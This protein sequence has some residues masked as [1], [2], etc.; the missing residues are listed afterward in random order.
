M[1]DGWNV[2]SG[3]ADKSGPPQRVH[4][5]EKESENDEGFF[6]KKRKKIWKKKSRKMGIRAHKFRTFGEFCPFPTRHA[7][8]HTMEGKGGKRG[9]PQMHYKPSLLISFKKWLFPNS[10]IRTLHKA[11]IYIYTHKIGQQI[12]DYNIIWS[13]Y[14]QR[15]QAVWS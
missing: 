5:K 8:C 7:S 10:S 4:K 3:C 1:F 12:D 9:Q 15:E 13:I 11:D 14:P 6:L 2:S